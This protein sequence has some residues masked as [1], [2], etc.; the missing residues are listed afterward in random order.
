MDSNADAPSHLSD[1]DFW[2]LC[3][4]PPAN[5][6]SSNVGAYRPAITIARK[7]PDARSNPSDGIVSILEFS[8]ES[9]ESIDAK[10][11]EESDEAA[12]SSS[13]DSLHNL[14]AKRNMANNLFIESHANR[15][16]TQRIYDTIGLFNDNLNENGGGSG[17]DSDVKFNSLTSN[18]SSSG[19]ASTTTMTT[20][21]TSASNADDL[22]IK[23]AKNLKQLKENVAE[24]GTA[25]KSDFDGDLI[26]FNDDN[27]NRSHGCN[28]ECDKVGS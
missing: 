18:E 9:D 15:V 6:K 16:N 17:H 25:A 27:D 1:S 7:S 26:D 14:Y 22:L 8:H 5:D 23:I 20:T 2:R 24:I 28:G 4:D 3:H 11:N 10:H 21:T 13:D 12:Q 19:S